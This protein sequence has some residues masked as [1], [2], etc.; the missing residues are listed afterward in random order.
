[1][2]KSQRDIEQLQQQV[3]ELAQAL[4]RQ[5][6]IIAKLVLGTQTIHRKVFAELYYPNGQLKQ[7]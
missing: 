1:M 7:T 3:Q 6:E 2:S 5:Q 4:H